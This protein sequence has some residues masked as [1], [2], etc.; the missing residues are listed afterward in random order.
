MKFLFDLGGVFFDWDPN[1]FFKD[2]FD[3]SNERKYF[4]TAVCNDEWNFKQDAGRTIEEAESELIPKFPH[5]EKQIKMYYK[6]HRKMLKG[7]FDESI[8]VLKKLK[9]L[10]YEC[11]VLSNWSAE[12][13]VGMTED[14]PFLKLFDGMLISGEDKLMKPDSA[15]YELA[16]NRFN[17]NPEETVFIDDKQENIEAAKG[18]DFKTIHLIDPKNIEIEINQFLI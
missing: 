5:Y 12:T 10:N 7:T 15:I 1:H 16:K 6:Y 3:T 8:K 18:L 14:Y 13:F 4:L 2:I 11:F 9:K 17:L